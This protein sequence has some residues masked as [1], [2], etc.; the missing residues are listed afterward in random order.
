MSHIFMI[1][2]LILSRDHIHTWSKHVIWRAYNKYKSVQISEFDWNHFKWQ[3]L[4]LGMD[5]KIK[6]CCVPIIF[7]HI[8]MI[9]FVI[10]SRDHIHIWSKHVTGEPIINTS[11]SK[12]LD[13]KSLQVASTVNI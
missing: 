13:L 3:E 1:V 5:D 11:H 7:S 12:Y 4:Y 6:F 2:F 8:F 9:V 10:L